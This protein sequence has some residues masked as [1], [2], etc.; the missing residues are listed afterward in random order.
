[1]EGNVQVKNFPTCKATANQQEK[2]EHEGSNVVKHLK[3][4]DR[5][6]V[7]ILDPEPKQQSK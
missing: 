2:V 3:I 4:E 1:M 7:E 5:G 6:S